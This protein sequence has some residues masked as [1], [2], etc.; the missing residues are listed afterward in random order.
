MHLSQ[1]STVM[2]VLLGREWKSHV[3]HS[4]SFDDPSGHHNPGQDICFNF[5]LFHFLGNL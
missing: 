5:C 4:S 2:Q 1:Y 3:V